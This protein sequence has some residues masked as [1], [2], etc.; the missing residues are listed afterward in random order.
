MGRRGGPLAR[1]LGAIVALCTDRNVLLREIDTLVS[2]YVG[3]V[4]GFVSYLK[5][6]G[7]RG[8]PET[9][10]RQARIRR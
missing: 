5:Y 2:G 7:R 3:A 9:M 8:M 6:K 1:G 10:N 4:I